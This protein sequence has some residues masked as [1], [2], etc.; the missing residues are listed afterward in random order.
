MWTKLKKMLDSTHLVAVLCGML[1]AA[2]VAWGTG[3]QKIEDHDRRLSKLEQ[4]SREDIRALREEM[5]AGFRD[6]KAEIKA[7]R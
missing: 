3:T 6:L 2:G 5:I 7:A 1:L 4:E